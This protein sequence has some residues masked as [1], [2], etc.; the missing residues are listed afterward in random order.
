MRRIFPAIAAALAVLLSSAFAPPATR[1]RIRWG[2]TICGMDQLW[3]THDTTGQPVI[4]RDNYWSP[5]H[6]CVQTAGRFSSAWRLTSSRGLRPGY[7]G[8]FPNVFYGCSYGKC[9]KNSVLP[10]RLPYATGIRVTYVTEPGLPRGTLNKALD[11]WVSVHKH[12]GGQAKGAEIMVW[13]AASY[14][15]PYGRLPIVRLGGWR[16]FVGHHRACNQ[17]GCWNYILFRRVIPTD[18]VHGLPLEPFF[19]WGEAH[20]LVSASWY[21]EGVEAGSEIGAVRPGLTVDE[22]AVRP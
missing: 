1:P 11:I 22:F 18:A 15:P 8:A 5:A 16:Y 10:E 9:S 14:T 20:G 4:I 21:L 13:L 7:I 3:R 17:L 6:V 12:V 2:A 19:A